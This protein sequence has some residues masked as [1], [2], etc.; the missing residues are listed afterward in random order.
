MNINLNIVINYKSKGR[1][2]HNLRPG[3]ISDHFHC[4]GATRR[5]VYSV[6]NTVI[7]SISLIVNVSLLLNTAF[8][9]VLFRKAALI[10]K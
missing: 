6:N 8:Y 9:A 1:L 10:A 4:S 3:D 5:I 7:Q 2:K